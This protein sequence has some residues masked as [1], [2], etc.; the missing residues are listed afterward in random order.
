MSK[1]NGLR[2]LLMHQ[3]QQFLRVLFSEPTGW[4]NM[5]REL[6]GD[7]LIIAFGLMMSLIFAGL[8][9]AG[10]VTLYEDILW[11][12]VLESVLVVGIT[13]LGIERVIED[14][15]RYMKQK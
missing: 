2:T 5:I 14:I 11:I 6:L 12:K 1:F 10:E 13:I 3:I 8:W 7:C 9:I 4:L 15:K